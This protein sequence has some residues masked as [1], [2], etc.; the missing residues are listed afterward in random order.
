MRKKSILQLL[1]EIIVIVLSPL[2]IL[3]YIMEVGDRM[4]KKYK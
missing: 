1:L 3:L 2:L 4:T